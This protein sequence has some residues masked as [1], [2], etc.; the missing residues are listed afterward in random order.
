MELLQP[1]HPPGPPGNRF[2][3]FWPPG[4]FVRGF[5]QARPAVASSVSEIVEESDDIVHVAV[6]KSVEKAESLLHWT[7]RRFGSCEICLVHVH[8]PSPLIPTLCKALSVK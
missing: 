6:G 1:S 2:S 5:D 8:Q 4:S 3:G 7:F